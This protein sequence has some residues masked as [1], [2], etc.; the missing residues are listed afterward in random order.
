MGPPAC[1]GPGRLRGL[2]LRTR[3]LPA[4]QDGLPAAVPDNVQDMEL[5]S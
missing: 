3:R 4:R 5:K 2:P 1:G